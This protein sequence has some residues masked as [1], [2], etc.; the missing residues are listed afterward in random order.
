M[1]TDFWNSERVDLRD[2]SEKE[3]TINSQ[4]FA[5]TLTALESR[6]E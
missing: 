4:R 6:I 1:L 5:E 2:F 3:T